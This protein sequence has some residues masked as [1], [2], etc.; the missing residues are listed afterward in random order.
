MA[1]RRGGVTRHG[2]AKRRGMAAEYRCW[3]NMRSRCHNERDKSFKNYGGRQISVCQR[4]RNSYENFL[5]DMSRKP[6]A[7]HSIDRIDN[8]GNYEPGN[9]RWATRSE[10]NRNQRPFSAERRA[11]ISEA[12]RRRPP[13]PGRPHTLASRAKIS[14]A[15]MGRKLSPDH[16]ASLMAG[17]KTHVARNRTNSLAT[18]E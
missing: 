8:D 10:Q 16:R 4:W 3:K 15:R 12:A 14:A 6:T 5:A 9:C 13:P 17:Y 18:R 11:K 2:D 1:N 7:A